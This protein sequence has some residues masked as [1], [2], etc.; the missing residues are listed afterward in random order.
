[1]QEQQQTMNFKFMLPKLD[2][3]VTRQDIVN[4]FFGQNIGIVYQIKTGKISSKD[5]YYYAFVKI[6][7]NDS[8]VSYNFRTNL[9]SFGYI[10]VM[11]HLG[12]GMWEVN[13][14]LPKEAC[15][16]NKT[17]K[18]MAEELMQI[19]QQQQMQ[20]SEEEKKFYDSLMMV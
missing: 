5:S 17:I 9:Q 4:A 12:T 14:I 7:L 20:L 18:T 2:M 11:N 16:E 6:H 15:R 1:M 10:N 13:T 8:L 3:S 19:P